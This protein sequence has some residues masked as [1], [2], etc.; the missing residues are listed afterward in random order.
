MVVVGRVA[1]GA[2]VESLEATALVQYTCPKLQLAETRFDFVSW[3]NLVEVLALNSRFLNIEPLPSIQL[4]FYL[5]IVVVIWPRVQSPE[6]QQTKF[7]WPQ[8]NLD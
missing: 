6:V 3:K 1:M 2:A 5:D 4:P 8:P 7:H